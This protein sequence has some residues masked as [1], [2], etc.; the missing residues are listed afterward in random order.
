MG[1]SI[2]DDEAMGSSRT[3]FASTNAGLGVAT[4]TAVALEKSARS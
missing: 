3:I 1:K 2:I 4:R